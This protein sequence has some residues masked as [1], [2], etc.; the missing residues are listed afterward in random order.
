MENY[1]KNNIVPHGLR[2]TLAPSQRCR[3]PTFINKWEKEASASSLCLMTLL[4]EEERTNLKTLDIQIAKKF[5]KEVEY[6]EKEKTLEKGLERFQY[7][8]KEHKQFNRDLSDFKENKVYSFFLNINNKTL[9]TD[10]STTE[11]DVLDIERDTTNRGKNL[12][13]GVVEVGTEAHAIEVKIDSIF[14]TNVPCTTSG[15]GTPRTR[16]RLYLMY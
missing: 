7:H 9:D 4:L 5:E 1:I 13:H 2:I 3:N 16:T 11:T 10:I 8:I 14:W 15:S 6:T 12:K